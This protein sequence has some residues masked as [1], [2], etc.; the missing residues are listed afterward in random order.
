MAENVPQLGKL[1]EGEAYRDAVHIA[2]AP[3][4]A[5]CILDPGD[6]IGLDDNGL[7]VHMK[8]DL[9]IGIV[10]PFLVD[11]VAPGQKF[12]L[13]LRPNTVTSLR[14]AWCHPAFRPKP[15]VVPADDSSGVND[16]SISIQG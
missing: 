12:W 8:Y 2:V 10:D 9:T 6:R 4:V 14:H 3:V 1:I 15:P 7:A 11:C 13:Y 16:D 5:G